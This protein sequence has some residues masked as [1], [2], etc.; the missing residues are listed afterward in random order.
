MAM[1]VAE[2]ITNRFIEELEKGHIPWQKPWKGGSSK[3]LFPCFSYSTG[4]RYDIINQMLL[5]FEQGDYITFNQ[6]QAL[7]GKVKKGAESKIVVGWIVKDEPCKDADGKVITDEDGNELTKPHFS[8]RY[9]RVFNVKDCEGITPKHDFDVEEVE[10]DGKVV[11]LHERAEQ[12]I[13]DYLARET[14]LQFINDEPSD[15]AYYSPSFDKVVVP[16]PSQFEQIEEYYSTSF[17]EL[18]HSTMKKSR[19]DRETDRK[20]KSVAFGSNE[21]SKEELIAEIG[22]ASLVNICGL[23][24]EKSFK[25][26]TAYLE[27]WI[28]ALKGDSNLLISA[29]AKVDDAINYILGVES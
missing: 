2:I 21:Y 18:T 10:D 19:C 29:C 7:G 12:I 4:K 27:S 14:S 1:K 22:S 16:M 3:E 23:E 20:G 24:T 11:D 6:V 8:L 15:R 26:S 25:N 28:K 9:Y 5:D 17:H 13:K